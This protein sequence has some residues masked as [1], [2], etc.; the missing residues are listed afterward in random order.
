M[1]IEVIEP[2]PL[3]NV[4]TLMLEL[5]YRFYEAEVDLPLLAHP[6]NIF[7]FNSRLELYYEN[8][9]QCPNFKIG[10]ICRYLP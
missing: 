7:G 3:F 9:I 1:D 2:S 6:V 4:P 5:G 10:W 8:N